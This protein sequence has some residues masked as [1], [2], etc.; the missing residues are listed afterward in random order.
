M[1]LLV[2]AQSDPACDPGCNCRSD[3]SICPIDN[4]LYLLLF[5]GIGYGIKKFR[6]SVKA[7]VEIQF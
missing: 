7:K 3:G 2:K 1:P 4:G 5:I 6:D